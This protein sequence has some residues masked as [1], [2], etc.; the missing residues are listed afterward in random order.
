MTP[1]KL[2]PPNSCL[3]IKLEQTQHLELNA[4]QGLTS[5][6]THYRSHYDNLPSQ[7]LDWSPHE[8]TV[9]VYE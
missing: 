9:L 4:E 2:P 7:S 3:H 5:R 6:S 8:A 1:P